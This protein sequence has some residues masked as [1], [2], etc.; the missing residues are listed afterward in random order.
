MA[1]LNYIDI[2]IINNMPDA[3]LQTTER[4]FLSLI[5]KAAG[6]TPVRVQF[7]ALPGVERSD[8]ARRHIANYE[9]V[10]SLWDRSL[11]GIIVTGA[12]P[13]AANLKLEPYWPALAKLVD[14]AKNNTTSA[15][16]SCLA[17]H[18]A[19]LHLAGVQRRLLT[20]KRF[21]VYT[22]TVA[23]DH[24]LM[25]GV[26]AEF[27]MPH[28]RWND[29]DER[30]LKS[31]GYSIL[32]RSVG[33][34]VFVKHGRSLFLFIQGHPEYEAE[35]LMLEYRRD[36][37]QFLAGESESYPN[38]PYDYVHAEAQA[39]LTAFRE[40]ALTH[41]S[42]SMMREFP[43]ISPMTNTWQP[44]AVHIYR[45]W[46]AYLAQHK[47]RKPALVAKENY[48]SLETDDTP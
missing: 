9:S 37:R 28:S 21:G 43:K 20:E 12:E 13:R 36:V 39:E 41:R 44:G 38:L 40:R 33:A 47:N 2:G 18:A 22:C 32:M 23:R 1:D 10:E 29:L 19:V 46:F 30:A 4:Q 35:T 25:A 14:W 31:A 45:N 34:D 7:Y 17:A 5:E 8:S 15:I 11:D 48:Y 3:A 42:E 26:P 6:R 24:A 16:W 27:A